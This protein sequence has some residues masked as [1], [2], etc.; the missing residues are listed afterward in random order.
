MRD[1]LPPYPSQIAGNNKQESFA[2]MQRRPERIHREDK[3]VNGAH[4]QSNGK[5]TESGRKLFPESVWRKINAE[6]KV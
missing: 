5:V 3:D 2:I 4:F 6:R 1:F